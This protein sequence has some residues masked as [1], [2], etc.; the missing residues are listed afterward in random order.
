MLRFKEHM[1]DFKF[2]QLFSIFLFS[3]ELAQL[4]G[5][6]TYWFFF[7]IFTFCAFKPTSRLLLLKIIKKHSY[8][9]LR[10]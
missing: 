3:L 2:A 7:P 4:S 8:A 6:E 9:S 10:R 5:K 1:L